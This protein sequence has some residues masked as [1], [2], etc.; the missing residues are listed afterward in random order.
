MKTLLKSLFVTALLIAGTAAAQTPTPVPASDDAPFIVGLSGTDLSNAS[1]TPQFSLGIPYSGSSG[2]YVYGQAT[3]TI[4]AGAWVIV[5]HNAAFSLADTTEAGSTS[6]RICVATG[7]MSNTSRFGW[8]WCG[9]GVFEAF[10][11]SGI[12]A[13]DAL[14]T[15]ATAGVA[16]TGG[17]SLVG[18]TA[19][20]AGVNDTTR[21]KV[22]CS[23]PSRT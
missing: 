10:V 11:A 22:F 21:V 2:F 7:A 13:G 8:A 6:K 18:C 4:T 9:G 15:T 17:D 3:E 12:S 1:E 14:T 19:V 20:E 23:V 5:N 16:G